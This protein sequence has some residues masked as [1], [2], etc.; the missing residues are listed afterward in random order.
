MFLA[1]AGWVWVVA[2]FVLFRLFD[3]WK[4]FPI[5]HFERRLSG[6]WGVMVDDVLAG[7]YAWSALQLLVWTVAARQ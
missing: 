1:P 2:G 6:G 7:V 3:I 5:R 4:P